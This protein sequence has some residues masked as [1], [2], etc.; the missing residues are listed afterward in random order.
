MASVEKKRVQV[1]RAFK[2]FLRGRPGPFF[3]VKSSPGLPREGFEAPYFLF[4]RL[5]RA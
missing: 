1:F 3:G 2:L 4:V 5:S